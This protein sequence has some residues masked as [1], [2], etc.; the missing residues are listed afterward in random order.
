MEPSQPTA[1]LPQPRTRPPQPHS[2][3]EDPHSISQ[4]ASPLNEAQHSL[5]I[6]Q[7]PTQPPLNP[8]PNHSSPSQLVTVHYKPSAAHLSLSHLKTGQPQPVSIYYK[9][10]QPIPAYPNPSTSLPQ[11]KD[12]PTTARHS[13]LQAICHQRP[14]PASLDLPQAINSS[15]QPAPA[16]P[17]VG[18]GGPQVAAASL[19]AACLVALAAP[20]SPQGKY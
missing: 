7:Q 1:S 16:M 20:V 5:S 4:L 13:I 17:P 6:Q 15:S 8:R 19:V 10:T 12:K 14:I 18:A 11:P 2:K 9:P 3:Q